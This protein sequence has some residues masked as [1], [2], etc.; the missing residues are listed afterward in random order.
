MSMMDRELTR[1][2]ARAMVA[3]LK[4]GET[5]PI[6]AI[7]AALARIAEAGPKINALPTL[8]AERARAAAQR[9]DRDSLLAGLPIAIKDLTDVAGVRTTYGSPIYADHV[10]ERSDVLV[11]RLEANGAIVLAKSN[12]PEFGAG[13]NSYNPVLGETT[14]PWNATLTSG[15]SSG[16]A[17]A[18][19]AAGEIWLATGSDMGGSLRTPASFCGVVGLR[20]TPG[21]IQRGPSELP[22]EM[23]AVEG[24]MARNVGDL[25]LLFDAMVG[26]SPIDP[27]SL[28]APTTPFLNAALTARRPRRVAFTPD[29]G[30]GAVEP[31]VAAVCRA[32]LKRWAAQGVEVV[33]DCPDLAELPFAFK[34]LRALGFV[35]GMHDLYDDPAKRALL[36]PENIW[37]I[38][39][40]LRL[41]GHQIGQAERARGRIYARMLEFLERYDLLIAPAAPCLP[42]DVKTRWPQSVAGRATPTYID[43]LFLS[44]AATVASLPALALPAG[45]S[46]Q[47]LPIGLQMIGLPLGEADLLSFGAD[48]EALQG[49]APRLPIEIAP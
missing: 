3:R 35:A 27:L 24:P 29:F 33:E 1:L 34:T 17:A 9:V 31:E 45:L 14:T 48:W 20:P 11:E 10:P 46:A 44:Y 40:G 19:L 8:C 12:T 30:I 5:T 6:Q 47:G 13:G 7:E 21:R 4:R 16:G 37:N 28:A 2:T 18:A 42:F 43:W 15:G 49:I 39:E 38:E 41:T 36:K 25:A 26:R 22:F 23:L 32:A